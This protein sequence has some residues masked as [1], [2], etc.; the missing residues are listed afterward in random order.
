MI[1]FTLVIILGALLLVVLLK[2]ARKPA[3]PSEPRHDWRTKPTSAPE[4][5]MPDL[6]NLKVTDAR[7]GDALSISGAGDDMSDLDFT[8]DRLTRVEAGARRWFELSGPYRER[9]VMLRVGGDEQVEAA[10]HN[11]ARTITL[12][13][14]GVSEDDLAQMD[15]RQNTG[16]SF[17]FEGKTWLYRFSR[18]ARPRR[19]DGQ[20][21]AAYYC[22]EFH[23][24]GGKGVLFMRK[25]EGEPFAVTDFITINASD[26]TIYRGR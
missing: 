5:E 2:L 11:T 6:A 3:A 1:T 18:E 8:A 7:P 17:E 19:D 16:D 24:Q 23:E 9:R 14:L 22:W 26:V 12:E 13:D 10:L 15:E 4:A 25:A 20:P 21:A